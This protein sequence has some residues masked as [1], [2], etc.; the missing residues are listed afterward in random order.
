MIL[1]STPLFL[2]LIALG[3]M[4]EGKT[5][6]QQGKSPSGGT[7][8]AIVGN[9]GTEVP[10]GI[11]PCTN[12][13]APNGRGRPEGGVVPSDITWSALTRPYGV[14]TASGRQRPAYDE[15]SLVRAI[16]DGVDAAGNQLAVTM[17]RFRMSAADMKALIGYIKRLGLESD[18][19]VAANVVTV[20]VFLP[21]FGTPL[22]ETVRTALNAWFSDLN[23]RGGIFGRRI[24][25]RY[26]TAGKTAES[27]LAT[28]RTMMAEEPVFALVAPYA[29][30]IEGD[31]ANLARETGTPVIGPFTRSPKSGFPVNREVFYLHSGPA[32][33]ARAL[34]NFALAEK[35]TDTPVA[36]VHPGTDPAM[37]NAVSAVQDLA[38]Q[39]GLPTPRLIAANRLP[40]GTTGMAQSLKAA[41][42][43]VIVY[44][45]LGSNAA[46]GAFLDEVRGLDWQPMLLVPADAVGTALLP[47]PPGSA[48]H[49][50][51]AFPNA[52]ENLSGEG[53]RRYARLQKKYNLPERPSASWL[54]AIAA[55]SL[56]EY[57]LQLAGRQLSRARLVDSL[58]GLYQWPTGFTPAVTY[59]PNRRIGARGGYI[60]TIDPAAGHMV[61]ASGWVDARPPPSASP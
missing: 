43:E 31:L 51:F 7:V 8:T 29:M 34:L 1:L 56:F 48:N 21:P 20:G 5:I 16:A 24:S 58:E 36:V 46:D 3:G 25:A 37:V 61:P 14:R 15:T 33:L 23:E 26:E 30:G 6:Y 47:P 12:C 19:G 42:I 57:G 50:Y 18:P 53:Y 55:A 54:E 38:T 35:G 40:D 17:P 39:R 32:D 45:G 49:V 41:G 27:R 44:L 28:L 4:G 2:S 13:H 10:G 11:M 52:Q 9:P 22:N 59:N 60:A